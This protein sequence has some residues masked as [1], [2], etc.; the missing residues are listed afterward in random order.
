MDLAAVEDL[1]G[2]LQAP[3]WSIQLPRCGRLIQ[4][5][6]PSRDELLSLTLG[7]YFFVMLGMIGKG[8][9]K[10]FMICLCRMGFRFG[11]AKRMLVLEF[12]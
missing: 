9:Q 11:S 5:A 4:F 6:I 8:W 12:R 1:A 3:P 10:N 2:P 7:M